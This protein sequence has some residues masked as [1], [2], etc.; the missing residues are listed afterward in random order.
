MIKQR[1]NFHSENKVYELRLG[2]TR[3]L[4]ILEPPR[5]TNMMKTKIEGL[6]DVVNKYQCEDRKGSRVNEYKLVESLK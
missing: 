1:F 3:V 2:E 5:D 6:L 4:C